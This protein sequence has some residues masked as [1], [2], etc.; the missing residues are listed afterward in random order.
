MRELTVVLDDEGLYTAIEAEAK[1]TGHTVQDIVI[2][3]LRQ[4]RDDCELGAME[5]TELAE[6]R[7]EWEEEGGVEAHV[8]FDALL[9]KGQSSQHTNL[10][11]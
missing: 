11:S 6:A 9:C 3:A 1:T 7:R 8:F 5:R 10:R 2:Q 4:W